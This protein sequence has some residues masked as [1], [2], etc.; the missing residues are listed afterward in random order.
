MRLLQKLKK[1]IRSKKQYFKQQIAI[2]DDY[3]PNAKPIGFRNYEFNLILKAIPEAHIWTMS[4]TKPGK[5]AFFTHSYGQDKKQ[6]EKNLDGYLKFHPENKD[7]VHWLNT[8]KK[9]SFQLAYS[10]FLCTTYTLLPFY[11]KNKIPFMF[12]LYPGGGFGLDNPSSDKMLKAVCQS[13]YFKGV[14]CTQPITYDYLIKKQFCKPEQIHF[15]FGGYLQFQP[16]DIPEKQYYPNDKKT[17]DICFVA[18]KYSVQGVD[19]GYDLFID[20]AKQLIK[21]Y[22]FVHFHV[23]GGF[24][25]TDIPIDE[26]KDKITFYGY[27]Q[28]HQ[29]SRFYSK[30]DIC[31]SP[32]RPFKLFQGNFDGFPL[33]VEAT[34]F[35]TVLAT[36]DELNNNQGYYID[37]KE[38]IIIRPEINDILSKI[39]PLLKNTERLYS[40]GHS[41]A[42]KTF[43]IMNP[44]KRAK[45]IIEFLKQNA[46]TNKTSTPN[47]S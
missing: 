7:R 41:G 5:D 46:D 31:L 12:V 18:A 38:L 32:N 3:I 6:F 10:I 40:I 22:S 13:P 33:A 37:G 17:L 20:T 25:E 39:E 28:P 16:Q 45:N 43:D 44:Q 30:M 21:K 15:E 11:N 23:V 42:I 36:T 2:I 8:K 14:I 24:D 19:K 35:Q 26:L 27:L 29:L 1:I 34:C 9:H 47:I 4:K